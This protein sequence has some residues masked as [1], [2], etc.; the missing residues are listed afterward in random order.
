MPDWTIERFKEYAFVVAL[1]YLA[2][3]LV[4]L[5]ARRFFASRQSWVAGQ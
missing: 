5:V 1:S 4:F 3:E 2:G